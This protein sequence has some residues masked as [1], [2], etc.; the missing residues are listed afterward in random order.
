MLLSS[1]AGSNHSLTWIVRKWILRSAWY[2]SWATRAVTP[3]LIIFCFLKNKSEKYNLETATSDI[4][5]KA[6]S[7]P[8]VPS[9]I[10]GSVGGHPTIYWN[11]GPGRLLPHCCYATV[12]VAPAAATDRGLCPPCP[13][14]AILK[15]PGYPDT[16]YLLATAGKHLSNFAMGASCSH[17]AVFYF[18]CGARGR[19]C[20]RTTVCTR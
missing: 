13:P 11:T 18:V 4:L 14:R 1:R 9:C 3:L 8:T 12:V 19:R 16:Q 15:V 5:C 7:H 10:T 20:H 17:A 2:T 6:F